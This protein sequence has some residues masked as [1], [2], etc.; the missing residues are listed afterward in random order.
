MPRS[1]PNY[2]TVD[3]VTGAV[4][5][6]FSGKIHA[7][8]LDLDAFTNPT[9]PDK[10]LIRWL[11]TTGVD[12]NAIGAYGL[13]GQHIGFLESIASPGQSASQQ[14][15]A[16]D[17]VDLMQ[18]EVRASNTGALGGPSAVNIVNGG[19]AILPTGTTVLD[20]LGASSFA[21]PA[22]FQHQSGTVAGVGAGGTTVCNLWGTIG[23][24][25]G[26]KINNPMFFAQSSGFVTAAP[27]IATYHLLI[28]GVDIGNAGF[29]FNNAG[30]HAMMTPVIG[31]SGPL[32]A[33]FHTIALS[34]P[35][36]P[37]NVDLNDGCAWAM[38]G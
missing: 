5:A 30:T 18:L 8:G 36:S 14:I 33:G 7:Q 35:F 3:P 29:F 21:Q 37:L 6:N 32:A 1:V 27:A 2:L 24:T 31:V 20:R 11:T 13:A 16:T 19:A 22:Q 9:P 10:D 4:G 15:D 25:L 28:D 17:G 26:R 12:I 34:N 23:F 38:I